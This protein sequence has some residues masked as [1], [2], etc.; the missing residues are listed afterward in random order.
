MKRLFRFLA[1]FLLIVCAAGFS[2]YYYVN[3]NYSKYV[4]INNY[5]DFHNVIFENNVDNENSIVIVPMKLQ[6]GQVSE[7]IVQE[8]AN[9]KQSNE[10]Y[11]KSITTTSTV[12]DGP[13]Y[14]KEVFLTFDDGPSANTDKILKILKDNNVK[15][16]FFVVGQNAQNYA[17]FLK[18]EYND[19]MCIIAH[20]YTHKYSIYQS[21]DTYM[22]DLDECNDVIKKITGADT[23]PFTRFPGGSDN[24]VSNSDTM[25]NIRKA[26]NAR[27]I[28]YVD[29]NVVSGDAESALVPAETLKNN[30]FSQLADVNFAVILMHDAPNK[31]TTVDSLPA[32]IDYLKK[33]GY[34][35][36]TFSELTPTEKSTMIKKRIMNR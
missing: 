8:T 27:K 7:D 17:D 23:L 20:S 25:S 32:L 14:P 26:V 11:L 9:Q 36:R 13:L 4:P 12:K 3:K 19:G 2:G 1:F 31:T 10:D 28:D 33:Q 18:Q 21:I 34:V 5:N 30:L 22:A 24:K 29:W 6:C 15:A 16:T 35:F